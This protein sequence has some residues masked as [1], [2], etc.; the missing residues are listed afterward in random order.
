M[1]EKILDNLSLPDIAFL[2]TTNKEINQRGPILSTLT[3]NLFNMIPLTWGSSKKTYKW[4]HKRNKKGQ[5]YLGVYLE[6]RRAVPKEEEFCAKINIQRLWEGGSG[7]L[8]E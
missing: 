2:S 5:T 3:K 7:L 8:L 4:S 6:R 1:L